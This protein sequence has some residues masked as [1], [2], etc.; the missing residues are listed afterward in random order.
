M[1]L[2]GDARFPGS[3]K[4]I[5]SL[6]IAVFFFSELTMF[7]NKEDVVNHCGVLKRNTTNNN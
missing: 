1:S 2:T 5:V 7:S 6:N 3:Y 4:G